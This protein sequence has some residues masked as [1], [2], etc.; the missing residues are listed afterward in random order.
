M[1][2]AAI[3]LIA[4]TTA[5]QTAALDD[6]A[7][8]AKAAVADACRRVA[9]RVLDLHLSPGRSVRSALHDVAAEIALREWLLDRTVV[10]FIAADGDGDVLAGVSLQIDDG[11]ALPDHLREFLAGWHVREV[12]VAPAE[13]TQTA[14]H[15]SGWENVSSQGLLL[16]HRAALFDLKTRALDEIVS[17]L[18]APAPQQANRLT[19]SGL[20]ARF[21][22][23]LVIDAANSP[24]FLAIQ[25][26]RVTANVPGHRII[27]ALRAAVSQTADPPIDESMLIQLNELI[28]ESELPITGYATPPRLEARGA[29][30]ELPPRVPLAWATSLIRVTGRGAV[31]SSLQDPADAI[32]A[33][34]RAAHT[35]A[36]IKLAEQVDKLI[37]PSQQSVTVGQYIR[38]HADHAAWWSAFLRSGRYSP[39]Q[40]ADGVCQVELVSDPSWLWEHIATGL[41]DWINQR[42]AA[43]QP[44][45]HF[46]EE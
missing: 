20:R 1:S 14:L 24:E 15:P 34:V 21:A 18:S 41:D 44:A 5:T 42:S 23:R 39:P 4:L 12:G 33:A 22:S 2:V 46:L 11:A 32:A 35:D 30:R 31:D 45:A 17:R 43:T 26:C 29:P 16:A 25:V 37:L 8:A 36:R 6:N 9:E 40:C 19:G 10:D 38:D 13:T 28:G 27:E 7:Y 3:A